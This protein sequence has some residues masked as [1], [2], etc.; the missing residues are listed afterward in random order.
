MKLQHKAWVMVGLTICL[1]SLSSV[2]VS[3]HSILASFDELEARQSDLESERARRLLA[4]QL[5]GLTA[6]LMDYAY[7]NETVEFIG[8]RRPEHFTEN[9]GT[10][11]MRYLGIS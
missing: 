5:D 4:Q 3:Q 6:T 9:F 11:N 2:L 1:L 7:W 8:G 10:D